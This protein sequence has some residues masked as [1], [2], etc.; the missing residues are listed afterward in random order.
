[1]KKFRGL[2]ESPAGSGESQMDIALPCMQRGFCQKGEWLHL[3]KSQFVQLNYLLFFLGACLCFYACMFVY[4]T[5]FVT[6]F[7]RTHVIIVLFYG[8]FTFHLLE[9]C[10][11]SLF[12]TVIEI[13]PGKLFQK[14]P[15]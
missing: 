3:P 15:C 13:F 9:L 10:S 6:E 2:D 5:L 11:P 7:L 14:F 8:Y 12:S 1:M 4:M